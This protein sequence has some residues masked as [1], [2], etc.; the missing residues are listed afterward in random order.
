MK[1]VKIFPPQQPHIQGTI[2]LNGS[3]S[4]S[5]RA[6]IIRALCEDD[7]AIENLSNAKD[8]VTLSNILQHPQSTIDAGAGGTTYRFLTA[9]LCCKPSK[10]VLTGSERMKERPIGVLVEALRKLDAT[11]DYLERDGYP[12]LAIDGSKIKGGKIIMPG[13]VSSQYLSAL[14]MIAPTLKGGLELEWTGTL[15]SRPYLLMTLN[16]MK[17]F[18]AEWEWTANAIK[19]KEGKYQARD[20]YVE[21]DWSAASYYYAIAAL[22]ESSDLVLRGLNEE[23]VQGDAVIAKMADLMLVHSAFDDYDKSVRITKSQ[24]SGADSFYY[25]FLECP[26]LAQT[27]IA[28]LGGLGVEGEFKGLQTLK[29]KETDRVAAMQHEMAKFG[30]IFEELDENHWKLSFDQ[31]FERTPISNIPTY[32]DHR[33]AM[34]IAPL[35]LKF[36][37]IIIE[38]PEVVSKS[39]PNFWADLESLG[40]LVEY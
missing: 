3:K 30:V 7:F 40:F 19:V 13:D 2:V 39:Y 1:V 37:S 33:M 20:F 34:A 26:D 4:I 11:I 32:E 10:F 27:I 31:S 21:G 8:T 36:G 28:L 12:P 14:L 35:C 15:V 17:Y 25:D 18:G 29:I 22:S 24:N 6:L 16:L 23:S 9:Y 38:E 5:N